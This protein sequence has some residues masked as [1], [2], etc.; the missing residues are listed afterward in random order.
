MCSIHKNEEAQYHC[1]EENVLICWNCV[2]L[3]EEHKESSIRGCQSFEL[4][5]YFE[6]TNIKL[7]EIKKRVNKQLEFGEGFIRGGSRIQSDSFVKNFMETWKLIE[8]FDN[9][10]ELQGVNV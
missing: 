8:M 4:A 10:D 3:H 5:Q 1:K 9:E 7:K 6:A 2:K